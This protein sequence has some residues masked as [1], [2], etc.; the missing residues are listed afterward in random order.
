MKKEKQGSIFVAHSDN[1]YVLGLTIGLNQNG[2][3]I[4]KQT[5]AGTEALQFILQH[6]PVVAILEAEL[7]LLSAYDIIKTVRSKE[8][9]TKFVVVFPT[10]E[11]PLLTP[12]TV[13]KIHDVYYCT[14]SIKIVCKVLTYLFDSPKSWLGNLIAQKFH[15]ATHDKL[16]MMQSLSNDELTLLLNLEDVQYIET[17]DDTSKSLEN[18]S[19]D[20]KDKLATIA[21]K[22]NS[23]PLHLKEW[24]TKNNT[25][26]KAFAL[27]IF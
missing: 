12:L 7:P 5:K 6:Q 26:L 21:L 24:S 16:K 2:Y 13:A 3:S 14:S 20:K 1:N 17:L 11:L 9:T 25:I 18:I 27:G 4:I 23:N 15:N 22:L 8:I 19:K 10:K